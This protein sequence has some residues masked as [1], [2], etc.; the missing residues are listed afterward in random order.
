M[1]RLEH[2][3][4]AKEEAERLGA[5]LDIEYGGKHIIGIIG[6]NGQ[7]RKTSFSVSPNGRHIAKQ[8]VKYI[9]QAVEEMQCQSK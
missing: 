1:R 6:F 5:T 3:E 9:R 8:T 2:I 4:A 7:H